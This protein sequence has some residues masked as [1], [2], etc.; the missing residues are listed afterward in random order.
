MHNSFPRLRQGL[1]WSL[2]HRVLAELSHHSKTLGHLIKGTE[3]LLVEEGQV[4]EKALRKTNLTEHDLMEALRSNGS[5]MSIES[6][7]AAYLERSGDVSVI[8]R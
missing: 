3:V 8:S 1:R 2:L 4:K 6:V 5:T 7:K